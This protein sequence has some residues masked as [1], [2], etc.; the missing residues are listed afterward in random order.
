MPNLISLSY[1]FQNRI[2]NMTVCLK[3]GEYF[4]KCFFELFPAIRF[5]LYC[6][7]VKNN[8]GF[9]LLSGLGFAVKKNIRIPIK[10]E[11]DLKFAPATSWQKN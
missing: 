5:N 10:N 7:K 6:F 1:I 8:T 3:G 4:F 2:V 11:I 9:P